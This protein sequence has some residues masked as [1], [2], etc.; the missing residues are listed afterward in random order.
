MFFSDDS[1][2]EAFYNWLKIEYNKLFEGWN[3]SYI[4]E[5]GRIDSEPLSWSYASLVLR[6]IQN[7]ESMLDM[8]TGG[9]EFLSYL[10]PLPPFTCATESYKP[11]VKI[12]CQKLE[13]LEVQVFEIEADDKLPFPDE[14]FDLIIN[15]HESYNVS[16]VYR[17]LKPGGRFI[18]QQVGGSNC[19]DL[20]RALGAAPDF[21]LTHWN[22]HFALKE[23][24]ESHF[25]ILE[26][27][28]E[29]PY[30]RFYDVGAIVFYLKAIPWQIPDFSV[31]KY[32]DN[33]DSLRCRIEEKGF[34]D[35]RSHRFL[36]VATK[37]EQILF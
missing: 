5:T 14:I 16:E 35:F 20:N 19:T 29:F 18:T 13:P 10:Q 7:I 28:E 37:D 30:N 11:N 15:R 4:S 31:E 17:I 36:I 22:L 33:L 27:K 3:F 21:G 12:A 23:L 2:K 32:F 1:Q 24:Q 34:L 9:G 6:E 26:Q 25:R 8:G